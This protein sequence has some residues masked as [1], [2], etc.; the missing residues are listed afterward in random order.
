VDWENPAL[1]RW[2]DNIIR[3]STKWGYKTFFRAYSMF[4]GKSA[5]ELIDEAL[6]DAKKDPGREETSF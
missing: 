5:S 6:E 3:K 1:K 2:L 4:T